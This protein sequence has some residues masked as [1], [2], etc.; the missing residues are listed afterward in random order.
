NPDLINNFARQFGINYIFFDKITDTQLFQKAGWEIWDGSWEEGILKFPEENPLAELSE[1]PAVLVISQKS[2]DAYDQ[3]F[4]LSSYG[5]IPYKDAFIVWGKGMIDDYSLEE[6]RKFDVLLLDGYTYKSWQKANKLL[7]EYV[8]GGGSVFIDTGWQY[9]VPDWETENALEIIPFK[10]L[11]W[12]DLGKT[13]DFALEDIEIVKEVDVSQF[14]P[15]IYQDQPWRVSTFEK[16]DLKDWA[17]V[18]LGVKDYPLIVVGKFGQGRVVWSGMNIF[19]HAKQGENIYYE[20]L[21]LL[22]NL[23]SWLTEGKSKVNLPVTYKREHPDKVEFIVGEDVPNGGFLLWKE[24]YHPD[25]QAT[26]ETTEKQQATTL[27]VYRAGPGLVAIKLPK[28]NKGERVVY[29]YHQ[30]LFEKVFTYLSFSTLIF[31]LVIIVEGAFLKEKSPFLRL[32]QFL[33]RRL[34]FLLFKLWQKPL[35]WWRR[36]EE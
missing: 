2:L 9:T 33:E 31:L 7:S 1:K 18:V 19:P 28:L 25:F 24:A 10:K 15:L 27:K 34:H 36:E 16:S 3:V 17:R 21:K 32:G 13:S 8:R 4:R 12:K 11:S 26:L 6:L 22:A 5:V 29:E 23:F 20:E 14:G 30:P 35:D